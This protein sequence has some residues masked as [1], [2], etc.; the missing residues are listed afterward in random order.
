MI[1]QILQRAG[2]ALTVGLSFVAAA[3]AV[4]A[5]AATPTMNAS[6]TI[7]DT[8]Y[9]PNNV[10]VYVGGN[11]SFTNSGSATHTAT[12]TGGAP[13]PFDTGGLSTGQST[14]FSMSL[15]GTYAFTSATDCLGGNSNPQFQCGGGVVNVLAPGASAPAAAAAPAPAA[16][17]PA[18]GGSAAA[19]A[20]VVMTDKG[21][22]PTTVTIGNG[23]T[24]TW[25]NNGNQ[26]HTA[27]TTG[28]T[29]VPF[30][31]G[32]LSAGQ[33]GSFNFS[34]PGTYTYTSSTDCVNN[35]NPGTFGCGPYVVIVS[36]TP[37]AGAPVTST[38]S[39]APVPILS[40][41]TVALTDQSG[42]S[43]NSLN[44]KVGS[45]VTWTNKGSTVHTS[46]S[47]PGYFNA[48]DSGGLAP[49][50]SFTYNF[51]VAGTYGYHSQTEPVYTTDS[52]TG[53]VVVSY[54]FTGTIIVS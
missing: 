51:T 19:T 16:P 37:V 45:S 29:P 36:A 49:G 11:V 12:T 50:Q 27:T 43:P 53:N 42:F 2:L 44:V 39:G 52:T 25:V 26:V 34:V 47:D 4:P 31:T 48:W 22:T 10:T 41:N 5:A 17:A 1:P 46:T 30:D 18:A 14:S 15:P 13:L 8:G 7:S 9:N 33:S 40:N 6:V 38:T 23:G 3:G 54:Q 24:V 28:T 20:S 32:G 35:S 21:V